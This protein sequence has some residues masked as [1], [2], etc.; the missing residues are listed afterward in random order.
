MTITYAFESYNVSPIA[1]MIII[2]TDD[3]EHEL[4]LQTIS[5]LLYVHTII[6]W[7]DTKII[8]Q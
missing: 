8:W 1:I 6:C 2:K 5:S 3:Y 4:F 7:C